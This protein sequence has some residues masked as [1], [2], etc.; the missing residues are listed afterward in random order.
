[1]GNEQLVVAAVGIVCVSVAPTRPLAKRGRTLGVGR[2]RTTVPRL[3]IGTGCFIRLVALVANHTV[4]RR[5]DEPALAAQCR[6]VL[7]NKNINHR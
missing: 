5:P 6:N 3:Q 7:R 1:M 4:T 2:D